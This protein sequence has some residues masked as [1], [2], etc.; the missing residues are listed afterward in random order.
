MW[1]RFSID[2]GKEDALS[3]QDAWGSGCVWC[4]CCL[5]CRMWTSCICQQFVGDI[6]RRAPLW[7]RLLRISSPFKHL[8]DLL[9]PHISVFACVWSFQPHSPLISAFCFC[10]LKPSTSLH[11]VSHS[12]PPMN[13]FQTHTNKKQWQLFKSFLLPEIRVQQTLRVPAL[14]SVSPAVDSWVWSS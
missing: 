7:V 11:C 5:I 14:L 12:V 3:L 13:Y 2:Q 4:C 6:L 8:E 9:H 1:L 10:W